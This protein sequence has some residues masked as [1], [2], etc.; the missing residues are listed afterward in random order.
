MVILSHVK[1]SYKIQRP[2]LRRRGVGGGGGG[3]GGGG[4]GSGDDGG[5]D[6]GHPICLNKKTLFS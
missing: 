2:R 5:G 1:R 3:G 6:S 4:S